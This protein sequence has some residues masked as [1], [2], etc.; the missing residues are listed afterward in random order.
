MKQ[1]LRIFA[2]TAVVVTLCA[3]ST[4][5]PTGA[6]RAGPMNTYV[7]GRPAKNSPAAALMN[8]YGPR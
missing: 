7:N 2:M 3:C 8:Q 5:A 6:R 4:S 1:T